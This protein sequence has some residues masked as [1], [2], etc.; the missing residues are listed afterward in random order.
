MHNLLH[1]VLLQSHLN[2]FYLNLI[3]C[4]YADVA[5]SRSKIAWLKQRLRLH[6]SIYE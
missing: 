4:A 3:S 1:N 5:L 6:P 2:K